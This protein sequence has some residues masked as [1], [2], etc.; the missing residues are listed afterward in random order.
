MVDAELLLKRD[1]GWDNE[2]LNQNDEG[3]LQNLEGR[4]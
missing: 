2:A 4:R 1:S 3:F